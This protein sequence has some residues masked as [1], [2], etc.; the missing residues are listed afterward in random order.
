[1]PPAQLWTASMLRPREPWAVAQA[2]MLHL[3]L[4][5][6]HGT[7]EEAEAGLATRAAAAHITG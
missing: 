6:V 1:V 2:L 4:P 5:V 7:V 3:A